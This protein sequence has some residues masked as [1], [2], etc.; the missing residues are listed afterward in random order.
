MNAR[1]VSVRDIDYTF[2]QHGIYHPAFAHAAASRMSKQMDTEVKQSF[3]NAL[4]STKAAAVW[5]VVLEKNQEPV[6]VAVNLKCAH[7]P[8]QFRRVLRVVL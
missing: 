4:T 2:P 7:V 1:V 3:I 8:L 6:H 5:A